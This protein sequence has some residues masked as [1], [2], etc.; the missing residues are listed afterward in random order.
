MLIF[1]EYIFYNIIFNCSLG[2]SVVAYQDAVSSMLTIRTSGCALLFSESSPQCSCC[3]KFQSTLH[4]MMRRLERA[5]NTPHPSDRTNFRYLTSPQKIDRM[6][7]LRADLR[8]SQKD[9]RGLRVKLEKRIQEESANVDGD[10]HK[11]LCAIMESNQDSITKKYEACYYLHCP[12][13]SNHIYI[14]T[15]LYN[16]HICTF[17]VHAQYSLLKTGSFPALFWG[18]QHQASQARNRRSMKWHPLMIRWCLY[19]RRLSSGAYE[20]LRSSGAVSLHLRE[21]YVTTCT[22]PKQLLALLCL[23]H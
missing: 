20:M 10:M 14:A 2:K 12:F 1:N 23:M 9:L 18:Q 8:Q 15:C 5:V 19:L 6:K 3:T 11:D 21:H 7:K 17:T 16:H 4:T 13:L 22:T